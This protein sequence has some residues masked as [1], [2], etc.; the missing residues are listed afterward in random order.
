RGEQVRQ[1]VASLLGTQI[2]ERDPIVRA[3]L[4]NVS[5]LPGDAERGRALFEVQCA[6]CHQAGQV[7]AGAGPNLAALSDRGL[8]SLLI[9]ILDPNRAVED[10]Y[11]AFNLEL[12]NGEDV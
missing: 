11:R 8:E 5:K 9:A 1:R 2:G 3:H 4:A 12:K 10:R 6:L 7:G